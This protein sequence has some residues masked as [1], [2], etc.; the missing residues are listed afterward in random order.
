M[1][2]DVSPDHVDIG[3]MSRNWKA[4]EAIRLDDDYTLECTKADANGKK[5]RVT[6]LQVA[7]DGVAV[8]V[9]MGGA[10]DQCLASLGGLTLAQKLL[11]GEI[12]L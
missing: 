7:S 12:R 2:L 6:Q 5:V 11:Q 10:A 9:K 3:D 1:F 8:V 4:T